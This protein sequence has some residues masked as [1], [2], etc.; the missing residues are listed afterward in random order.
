[1]STKGSPNLQ[2]AS[3]AELYTFVPDL[4]HFLKFQLMAAHFQLMTKSAGWG[5]LSDSCNFRH[6]PTRT[7]SILYVTI[8]KFHTFCGDESDIL[9]IPCCE[10]TLHQHPLF[11]SRVPEIGWQVHVV[12][13][14]NN[15]CHTMCMYCLCTPLK[16]KYSYIFVNDSQSAT[17]QLPGS[18]HGQDLHMGHRQCTRLTYICVAKI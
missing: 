14:T 9:P 7:T 1:M 5:G 15:Y 11:N 6:V 12:C 4:A 17:N 18:P 3:V 8:H 16:A 2:T 13:G 10:W